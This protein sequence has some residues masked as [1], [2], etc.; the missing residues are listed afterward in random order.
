[1]IYRETLSKAIS[2]C[3]LDW[4]PV[5]IFSV[6][7]WILNYL[8]GSTMGAGAQSPGLMLF[9]ILASLLQMYLHVLVVLRSNDHWHNQSQDWS[10]ILKEASLGTISFILYSL[11]LLLILLFAGGFF[12]LLF[13]TLFTKLFGSG[14]SKIV[15]PIL[16]TIPTT[17]LLATILTPFF[18]LPW[19]A[20][21]DQNHEQSYLKMARSIVKN[22]RWSLSMLIWS[23][24]LFFVVGNV[25]EFVSMGDQSNETLI[26][27]FLSALFVPIGIILD[28]FLVGLYWKLKSF[29]TP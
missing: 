26:W 23:L 28:Y 2:F 22:K 8:L 27:N 20:V 17:L 19:I 16:T 5:L 25:L 14:F 11:L 4:K 24:L 7:I 6:I 3:R 12:G 15:L 21:I 1:M 29:S 10:Q 13:Y 9:A 18:L